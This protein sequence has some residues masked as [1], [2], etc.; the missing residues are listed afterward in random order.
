LQTKCI[1]LTFPEYDDYRIDSS[2]LYVNQQIIKHL[3]PNPN[4]YC[5]NT[6]NTFKLIGE[7]AR[8]VNMLDGHP[9]KKINR[10]VADS[11]YRIIREADKARP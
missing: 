2:D 4:L 6:T 7:S 9:S 10:M 5:F 1:L 8:R 3:N 11:L